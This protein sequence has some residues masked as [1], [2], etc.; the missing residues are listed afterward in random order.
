M[1]EFFQSGQDFCFG[2]GD[3]KLLDSVGTVEAS[4]CR[5]LCSLILFLIFQLNFDLLLLLPMLL[6]QPLLAPSQPPSNPMDNCSCNSLCSR[7]KSNLINSFCC[8]H[9][10]YLF[11]RTEM[12]LVLDILNFLVTS[13]P[14]VF[15]MKVLLA[16]KDE[17]IEHQ[18][19]KTFKLILNITE[20]QESKYDF[21]SSASSQSF[22]HQR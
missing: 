18:L 21:E 6:L 22:N 15:N 11:Y 9:F 14:G 8:K 2:E 16:L 1:G 7:G 19:N 5:P 4:T 13:E 10:L 12:K 3:R 20:V 17:I